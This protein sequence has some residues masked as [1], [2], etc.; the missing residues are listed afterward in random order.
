MANLKARSATLSCVAIS[1]GRSFLAIGTGWHIW[2]E[3]NSTAA[4]RGTHMMDLEY[5]LVIKATDDPNFFGFYSPNLEGFTGFGHAIE[6][7]LYNGGS[8]S[9]L[10]Y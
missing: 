1:G 6:D 3:L 8:R 5:T 2:S 9:I 10:V 7:C 4:A